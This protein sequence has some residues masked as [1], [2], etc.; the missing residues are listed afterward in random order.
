[1]LTECAMV[2]DGVEGGWVEFGE[3]RVR[4]LAVKAFLETVDPAKLVT[5]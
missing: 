1:V 3:G 4:V 5:N 2:G